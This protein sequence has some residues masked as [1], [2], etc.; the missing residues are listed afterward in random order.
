M[1]Q[2]GS[3]SNAIQD[4]ITNFK[5]SKES[6]ADFLEIGGPLFGALEANRTEQGA[7]F[8]HMADQ[9]NW[10]LGAMGAYGDAAGQIGQGTTRAISQAQQNMASRGLGRG[11]GQT[12]LTALLQQQGANQQAGLRAQLQ[13]KAAQNRMASAG[14]LFSAQQSI[15]QMALGQGI[16]PRINSPQGSD[17]GIGGIGQGAAAGASMGAVAGPWGALIG[18]VA[19]AGYGA[20]QNKK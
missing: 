6:L 4:L 2:G 19:G 14:N 17:Q 13:Q 18:G 3:A 7:A 16:T 12:A 8:Q 5:G 9:S 15:A 10:D 20:Y 1:E 11:A